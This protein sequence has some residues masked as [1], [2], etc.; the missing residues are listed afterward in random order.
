MGGDF[1]ERIIAEQPCFDLDAGKRQILADTG[2]FVVSELDL[3]RMDSKLR[4]LP[5]VCSA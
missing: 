1:L 4:F 2:H 3:Q 5:L